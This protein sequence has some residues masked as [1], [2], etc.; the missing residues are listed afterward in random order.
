MRI[1]I[2]KLTTD[3]HVCVWTC[4]HLLVDGWSLNIIL[5][6]VFHVYAADVDGYAH[7]L[8]PVRPYRDY[9]AWLKQQDL[10]QAESYW[11]QALQG[12]GA[13]TQIKPQ[14]GLPTAPTPEDY[15]LDTVDLSV[16]TSNALRLL[17]NQHMLTLNTFVQGAWA[18][19]L[20]RHS[21]EEDVVFGATVAGR[22]TVIPG[23]EQMVGL[24]IN[25]LPVRIR[26][27]Q[28]QPLLEW[29]RDI[30]TQQSEARAYEHSPLVQVQSWSAVPRGTPLFESLLAFENF[31]RQNRT[32]Q[33]ASSL[34]LEQ[35]ELDDYTNYPLD[36]EVIPSEQIT[37]RLRYNRQRYSTEESRRLLARYGAILDQ[38]ANMPQSVLAQITMIA[39]EE[40]QLLLADFNGIQTTYPS[41]PQLAHDLFE[42]AARQHPNKIA[43]IYQ[44]QR[45]TFAELNQRAN[46][47]AAALIEDGLRPEAFVGLFVERSHYA[48]IGALA[49]FKASGAYVP[50]DPAYP[51]DRL[52]LML[53]DAAPTVVMTLSGLRGELPSAYT[54]PIIELDTL[55]Y[56]RFPSENPPRH[57]TPENVAYLIYTSGTTGRPKGVLIQHDS[58]WKTCLNYVTGYRLDSFDAVAMNLGSISFD[59]FNGDMARSIFIG[60]TLVICP[61]DTRLDPKA[62]YNLIA[63]EQ[64][65]IFESTPV[66]INAFLDYI[67]TEQKDLSWFRVLI[68]S[69]DAWR[70]IDYRNLRDKLSPHI[71]LI[72]AYGIT[73]A[74]ID[75]T[76]YA[77]ETTRHPDLPFVSIGKP[78][79]NIRLYILDSQRQLI[80]QGLIGELYIGGPCLA[81]GYLHQEAITNERFVTDPFVPDAR[82]YKTGDLARWLPDGTI[83][84]LGRSDHQVKIRGFR[85]ELGEIESLLRTHPAVRDV[86]VMVRDEDNTRHLVGYVVIDPAHTPTPASLRDFLRRTLP[87]YMLPVA[88]VFMERLPIS[89]NGKLDRK[90]LPSPTAEA[91]IQAPNQVA[92][93]TPLEQQIAQVWST[94]LGQAVES[95]DSNFFDLGGHSLLVMQVIARLRDQTKSNL[96]LR[97]LFEAP[98]IAGL[99]AAIEQCQDQVQTP[100]LPIQPG[101]RPERIPLSFAQQRLWF[102]DQLEPE[103]AAYNL[104][105]AVRIRGVLQVAPLNQ[106]LTP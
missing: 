24:F 53:E 32:Q 48:V 49:A 52:E 12:F 68:S 23:I 99:A 63:K 40:R 28:D 67:I 60:A 84:F 8:T 38:M 95:V 87:T 54:G 58:Y 45:L 10:G 15:A 78:F 61:N 70:T 93:R 85:I 17:A 101:Q 69:A 3:E 5:Q 4:H 94:V 1:N 103:S 35:L 64:V 21:G 66:L 106:A 37:L 43:L 22:P 2:V 19:L 102:L 46:Q 25:T 88:F 97:M 14:T 36:V 13:P 20:S 77:E 47:L 81:R 44:Q 91:W 34:R 74:T 71:R 7:G 29:L 75:S 55:E 33:P 16:D 104:T 82:M 30:Q 80:P 92:P 39:A 73:E 100:Q 96:P 76:F 18:L 89:P 98:T 51:R 83:E 105:S 11:R 42:Q 41:T 90:L 31:P 26:I 56:S 59:V 9:I 72:N 6:E 50:L 65:N 27:N 86:V 57:C 79:P 62:L